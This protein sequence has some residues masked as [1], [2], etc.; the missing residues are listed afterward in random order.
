MIL[1]A[2]IAGYSLSRTTTPKK[3]S[4][5]SLRSIRLRS[6]SNVVSPAIVI[7]FPACVTVLPTSLLSSLFPDRYT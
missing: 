1:L 7:A 2:T 5:I 6:G 3:A 4:W